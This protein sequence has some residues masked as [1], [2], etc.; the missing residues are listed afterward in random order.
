MHIKIYLNFGRGG[1]WE[2]ERS[3]SNKVTHTQV[4]LNGG[5]T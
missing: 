1:E 5:Y 3:S 2:R 4:C